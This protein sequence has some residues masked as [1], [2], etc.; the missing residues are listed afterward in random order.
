MPMLK[1]EMRRN[2]E[3]TAKQ[4]DQARRTSRVGK[5]ANGCEVRFS[6]RIF[7]SYDVENVV[8]ELRVFDDF[9]VLDIE[10]DQLKRWPGARRPEA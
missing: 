4:N 1:N 8:R 2:T 7:E 6:Q 9:A 10:H 5:M 3:W